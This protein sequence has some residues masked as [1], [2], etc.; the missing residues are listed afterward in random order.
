M[1]TL[2]KN[3]SGAQLYRA[4]T[5]AKGTVIDSNPSRILVDMPGG[6]TGIVTK[7]EA[8]TF[9]DSE[10]AVEVGSEIEAV[11]IEAENEQGLVML[12]LRKAS[13]DMAWAELN[14]MLEAERIMTVKVLEAN[15]GGLMAT[16]KGLKC[17][18]PV[19]QLAPLNYP[20]VDGA[21]SAAIFARLQK[22][23]G[24]E[25]AVRVINVQRENGK[26][27]ISERAA[28]AEKAQETLKKLQVGDI[29]KGTVS[30]IVKFGIFVHFG[31]VEGLVHLSEMDWSHVTDP[32]RHYSL[33][34]EVE[35]MVIGI[36][37]RKLSFSIKRLTEDPWKDRVKEF[38]VGQE[39]SGKVTRWNPQGVFIELKDGVQGFFSLNQFPV[40]AH[41]EL[42]SKC[43]IRDGVEL[44]GEV[45][46]INYDSHRLELNRVD[47]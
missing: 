23:I 40:E 7:K 3:G 22:H 26:V 5:T 15:K 34:D 43:A 4:G 12:S 25:F 21:D 35:I 18:L 28:M 33:G 27:I 10:G 6:L 39:L 32:S 11:V 2:L 9:G 41:S 45:T 30:G 17:F 16:F 44:R 37:G 14:E 38:E 8:A 19:S 29:V 31:G 1:K 46:N 20:R 13:L 36:D 42:P 47:G 24:S